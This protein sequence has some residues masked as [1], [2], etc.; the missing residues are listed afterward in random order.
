MSK[1]IR[2]EFAEKAVREITGVMSLAGQ[3]HAE[4]VG[5]LA[6]KAA[7][8]DAVEWANALACAEAAI[9]VTLLQPLIAASLT[10]AIAEAKQEFDAGKN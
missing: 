2:R 9:T 4:R 10:D 7:T 1:T 3:R 5:K 8:L 6:I